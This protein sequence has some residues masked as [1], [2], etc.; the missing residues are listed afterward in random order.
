MEKRQ[1]GLET[2]YKNYDSE[3]N[4]FYHID[5][6][7]VTGASTT[8]PTSNNPTP[9]PNQL[10]QEKEEWESSLL[11]VRT[12]ITNTTITFAF[13]SLHFTV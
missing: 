10:K 4:G 2:T 11:S 9:Q 13:F 8:S 5:M 3:M 6:T 1:K 7:P 12:N